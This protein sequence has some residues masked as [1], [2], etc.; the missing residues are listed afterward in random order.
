MRLRYTISKM[1][2]RTKR[3]TYEKTEFLK[4]MI[5]NGTKHLDELAEYFNLNESKTYIKSDN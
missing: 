5:E 3:Y 2:L 4:G 1:A